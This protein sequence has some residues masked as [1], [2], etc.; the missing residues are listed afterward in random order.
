MPWDDP[1]SPPL[2]FNGT[3][4]ELGWKL[5]D[6]GFAR[7]GSDGSFPNTVD[8]FHQTSF[9]VEASAR[10][11]LLSRE[12]NPAVY[13][14]TLA[15]YTDKLTD[16]ANW[17]RGPDGT[18]VARRGR[19]NNRFYGHRRWLL[20][21]ALGQTAQL[22]GDPAIEAEARLYADDDL[23]READGGALVRDPYNDSLQKPAGWR[24]AIYPNDQGKLISKLLA[25]G[26][27]APG[28][29]VEVISAEGVN[30]E[31]GGFDV[32]YQAV[33]LLYAARY[34]LACPDPE[35]RAKVRDMIY[36]GLVW[37]MGR[38]D[39]NT[40]EV[41]IRGSTRV[42]VE[43]GGDNQPK[44]VDYKSVFQAFVL[45]FHITGDARFREVAERIARG[46][47]WNLPPT[48][49]IAAPYEGATFTAP[50]TITIS[51]EASDSDGGI[52]RV[53]F[54]ADDGVNNVKIGE[55][56]TAPYS[57]T[58]T[59]APAGSYRLTAKATESHPEGR[60][61][62]VSSTPVSIGVNLVLNPTADAFVRDGNYAD[63][64]YGAA[65]TLNVKT[66]GIGLNRDAYLK[67]NLNVS[68]APTR[69]ASAKLRIWA[70][71]STTEDAAIMTSVYSVS[72]TPAWT[73]G[74]LTWN[75][76]PNLGGALSSVSVSGTTYAWYEMDVTSHVQA[77]RRD[78]QTVVGLAL[79]N[80]ASSDAGINLHARE[81]VN[82]PQLVI[83]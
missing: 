63:T 21:A 28:G 77:Q 12:H 7:Q 49:R 80:P 56:T 16:A 82:K 62:V 8:P 58:W 75:T 83:R 47:G 9:F 33:G 6:W 2:V 38:V 25:P 15:H 10:A 69:I 14:D 52:S 22:T 79:H 73:E 34:Y 4:V 26:E 19:S 44:Q 64:N 51:A 27:T 59:G 43:L 81:A 45:G 41:V 70:A 66:G 74:G 50:A 30:P 76:R 5:L 67:F 42:G 18:D 60:G 78:G 11:L 29:T 54:F 17:L 48:V 71:L 32:S 1:V 46:R 35:L 37:E 53:E 55:D 68:G 3:L 36:R 31:K 57:L 40:G 24:A 72:R 65:G 23:Y 20:A 39:E 13:A 61:E